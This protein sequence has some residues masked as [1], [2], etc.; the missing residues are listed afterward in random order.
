MVSI[1]GVYGFAV[2]WV[3]GFCCGCRRVIFI[4]G[5]FVLMVVGSGGAFDLTG[6][7]NEAC[8]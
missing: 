2:E 3:S 4:V 8:Y 7:V 1:F 5:F 6:L